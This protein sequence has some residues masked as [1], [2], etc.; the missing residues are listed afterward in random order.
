M[1]FNRGHS[2]QNLTEW[3]LRLVLLEL[4]YNIGRVRNCRNLVGT[5]KESCFQLS[6][7]YSVSARMAL[8]IRSWSFLGSLEMAT[9][10][11][12]AMPSDA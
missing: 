12:E 7:D 4:L 5:K 2:W 9:E 8:S 3:S 10:S 1:I 6:R 11:S